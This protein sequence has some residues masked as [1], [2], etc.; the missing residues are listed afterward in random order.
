MHYFDFNQKIFEVGE[1]GT[2]GVV[3]W[4]LGGLGAKSYRTLIAELGDDIKKKPLKTVQEAAERLIEKVWLAFNSFSLKKRY[5]DL[6]AKPSHNPA[7]P[8]NAANRTADEDKELTKLKE[9]LVIGFCVAGFVLPNRSVAAATILFDPAAPKPTPKMTTSEGWS[10]S[11]APNIIQRLV[12]GID[13]A[14]KKAVI[15]SGKWQGSE[16]ELDQLVQAHK[17][18]HATLPIRDAVD[19]VHSSIYCTIKALKF[20]SLAQTCGGP[21]ELAVITTDRKFRWVRHKSWDAA[22]ND[23]DIKDD[24]FRHAKHFT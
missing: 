4:G 12:Y 14:L 23:G 16:Q 7:D 15:D 8:K 3:T 2:L 13:P 17:L 10:W 21:V 20:S 6:A 5:D 9:A 1:G 11:G 22:I 18:S 19:Y 24:L